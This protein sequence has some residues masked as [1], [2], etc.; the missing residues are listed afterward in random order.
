MSKFNGL[1]G[2]RDVRKRSIEFA[3]TVPFYVYDGPTLPLYDSVTVLRVPVFM[4]E[5]RRDLV[6]PTDCAAR[7]F[8]AISAPS[9]TS[10]WFERTA[11]FPFLEEPERFH[12]A[13]LDVVSRTPVLSR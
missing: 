11:H 10:I 1:L 8:D 9:K 2:H 12:Q 3:L 7:L 4:F 13:L 5:G 6:A